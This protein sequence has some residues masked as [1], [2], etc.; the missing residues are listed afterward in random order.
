MKNLILS[1]PL[2]AIDTETTG[3]LPDG[4][5]VELGAHKVRPDGSTADLFGRLDPGVPIPAAATAVHGITDEHVRGNLMWADIWP[6]LVTFCDDC[7]V[8][9]FNLLAFDALII[10]GECER[11][12]LDAGELF[13]ARSLIDPMLIFHH[14]VFA[15][16][17]PPRGQG[18]LRAAV[19]HYLG[20]EH[21]GAHGAEA[22]ARAALEVLDAQVVAHDLPRTVPE[23]NQWPFEPR[24]LFPAPA[25]APEPEPARLVQGR[26]LETH[27]DLHGPYGPGV[28][29]DRP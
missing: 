7:D 14:Q 18:T 17:Y 21:V 2:V 19:R 4:R 27:P 10:R 23:L 26:L 9:G 8:L 22:D 1:R 13:R 25:A 12:G 16:D 29:R 5:V 3:L 11:A 28:G 6:T 24:E 15:G 20:R